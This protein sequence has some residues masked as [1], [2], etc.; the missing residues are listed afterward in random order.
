[1]TSTKWRLIS[2]KLVV[3]NFGIKYIGKEHVKHLISILKKNYKNKEDWE[4]K[5]YLEITMDWDYKNHEE[6]LP[7]PKYVECALAQFGHPLPVEPEHQ[8]HQHA[9]P[10]YR[11]TIQYV[12]PEDTSRHTFARQEEIHSRRDMC[13]PLLGSCHILHHA[14]CSL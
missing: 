14:H 13:L 10:T 12:K 1:L 6:S 2:F 4:G 11:A 3:D 9:I 7:L 8:P 5:R